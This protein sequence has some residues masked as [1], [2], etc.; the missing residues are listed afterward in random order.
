M[1]NHR[2]PSYHRR[3]RVWQTAYLLAM[4]PPKHLTLQPNEV[5]QAE[6]ISLK[7]AKQILRRHKLSPLGDL[8][9]SYA[10]YRRLFSAIDKL[11]K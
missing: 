4:E 10:Y 6:F 11:S 2:W 1:Y 5:E 3:S 7:R 9:P 8:A